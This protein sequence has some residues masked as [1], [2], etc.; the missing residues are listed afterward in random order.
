MKPG[1]KNTTN[2]YLKE[3]LTQDKKFVQVRSSLPSHSFL[4]FYK[5]D[6]KNEEAN[7]TDDYKDFMLNT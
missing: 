2:A 7:S 6:K 1:T 3:I 4:Y 5:L